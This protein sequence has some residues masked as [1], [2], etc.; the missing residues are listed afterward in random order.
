ML[1]VFIVVRSDKGKGSGECEGN[2]QWVGWVKFF[3]EGSGKWRHTFSRHMI[4]FRV[5]SVC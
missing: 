1:V 5:Q 4:A 2:E 3:E